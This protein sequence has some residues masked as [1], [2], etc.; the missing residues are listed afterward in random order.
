MKP[1]GKTSNSQE[2]D[3][4]PI[5]TE[6]SGEIYS[7]KNTPDNKQS[8]LDDQE[9]TNFRFVVASWALPIDQ[10]VQM[11]LFSMYSSFCHLPG[12]CH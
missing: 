3:I 7:P 4:Q 12:N 1:Q 2:N 5:N 9:P 6:I 11:V 8:S 10:S